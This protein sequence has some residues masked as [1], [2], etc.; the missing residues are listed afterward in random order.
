M[1]GVAR[2]AQ[3]A[4]WQTY[5]DPRARRTGAAASLST[6]TFSGLNGA[7]YTTSY[8]QFGAGSAD[9]VSAGNN[10]IMQ[11]TS[12]SGPFPSGTGDFCIEGWVY[13]PASRGTASTGDPIV[14]NQ[15]GGLGI[16]FGSGYNTGGFNYLSLFARGQADLDYAAFTWPDDTWCHWAVQRRSATMSFWANGNKLSVTG[17]SGGGAR[18]FAAPSSATLSIGSYNNG[19][20]TD[21]TMRSYLDEICVSNSWR[22]DDSYS[23]YTIPTAAFTVDVYTDM[24]IH[25]DSSLT[26]A[27]T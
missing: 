20:S 12:W 4:G 17:G 5:T 21:E 7:T 26:T 22:Y 27:G 10:R 16:R 18:N 8:A 24:L 15:T 25:F 1:L 11:Y 9:L 23:T 6:F 19:G 13:K 3:I 2:T 14:N